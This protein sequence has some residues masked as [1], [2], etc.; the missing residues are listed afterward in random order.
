VDWFKQ[1]PPPP[2]RQGGT[3]GK[4]CLP[5]SASFSPRPI[6]R[7]P[8]PGKKGWSVGFCAMRVCDR[9][10]RATNRT[11]LYI[12]WVGRR[13]HEMECPVVLL[14]GGAVPWTG[15]LSSDGYRILVLP[16]ACEFRF[17]T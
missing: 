12:A 13:R 3:G 1:S 17:V 15:L 5:S 6:C 8:G 10:L 11:V 2:C 14:H 4:S 9:G 7:R 16:M